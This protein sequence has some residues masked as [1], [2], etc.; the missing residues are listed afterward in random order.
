MHIHRAGNTEVPA[1][2][3]L[4]EKGYEVSWKFRSKEEIKLGKYPKLVHNVD[5]EAKKGNVSFS[6]YSIVEL[7]GLVAMWE[8]RGNN[9]QTKTDE[10]NPLEELLQLIENDYR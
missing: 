2:L 7:L 4:Q 6:A 3:A 8:T 5:F 10:P 1:F 9:W